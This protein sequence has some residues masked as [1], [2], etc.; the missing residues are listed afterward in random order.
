[1]KKIKQFTR[2]C[3]VVILIGLSSNSIYANDAFETNSP[4]MLGDWSGKRSQL[5]E[6]GYDFSISYLGEAATILDSKKESNHD[7]AYA[8]HWGFAVGFDLNKILNW[9]GAEAYINITQRNG[10]QVE[11][12]SDVLASHI[13]QVQEVYGRGQTWRLTDLWVKQKLLNEKLDIK[14][15]RFGQSEDFASFDCEFQNLALCGGQIGH[16]SGDQWFNGPVSQWAARVKYNINP[17]MYTQIGVYEYNPR[18]LDRNKGF[19]LSTDGSQGAIIPLELVWKPKLNSN[20]L[21][22]EYRFGYYFGTADADNVQTTTIEN[23]HKSG[24]WVSFKQKV[25]QDS[26]N[27]SRGLTVMGQVA[28]YDN[29][30]SI[31]ND[32]ENI[33]LVYKGLFDSRVQDEVGLGV[34][35]IGLDSELNPELDHELNAELYYGIHATDYLTIRPNIQY[36]D[37]IGGDVKN[38]DAWLAGLKFNINF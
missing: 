29:K 2:S 35:R 12:K 20:E 6:Q 18:N 28:M 15:G 1:M 23:V 33:A 11:H 9:N 5:K 3:S 19:N 36:V 34:S 27:P 38:G 14:I 22:G 21:D 16:W 4:W 30:S 10:N 32:A 37:H 31:F 25:S 17:E 26:D 24:A 13:S 7:S 8:D